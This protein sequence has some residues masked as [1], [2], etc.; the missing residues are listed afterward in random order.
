VTWTPGYDRFM[1]GHPRHAISAADLAIGIALTAFGLR[2]T[3]N[4]D[5]GGGGVWVDS[6]VIAAVTLPV[7]WRWRVPLASAAALAGGTVV[8]AIPTFDQVR[9]GAAIPAA[10]LVL[11]AVAIRS[12]KRQAI[13]GLGLLLAGM[14]FLCFTDP[15]LSWAA[16]P[17][18]VYPL[19]PLCI[20]VWAAGRVVRSRN[21]LAAELAERSRALARQRERTTQLAVEVERTWLAAQ[22]DAATRRRVREMID[23]TERGER[24]LAQDPER[25]RQV[26]AG[27]ESAGRESLNEMRGLL[28]VLRSEG[29]PGRFPQ[30]TLAQLGSLLD[31][32]RSVG[33]HV[34]FHVDGERQSLPASIEL[35]AYRM[36]EHALAAIGDAVTV[37]LRYLPDT[38][39]LE[40]S[41]TVSA[42]E[43][44]DAA[45]AAAREQV[46]THGGNFT[47]LTRRSGL[48]VLRA[49]LPVSVAHV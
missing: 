20:G 48:T 2:I 22:L 21:R 30:P 12:E 47:A 13:G 9:C 40:V 31:D 36:A 33:R 24:T 26:F 23:L 32:A 18:F 38:L 25:A 8:S 27:I 7:I 19:A 45:L 44:A 34:D 17:L 49:R 42:T 46:S 39:E 10:L 6:L 43:G 15:N 11:Y 3:L 4:P 37:R 35:A 14:L 29:E 1:T 28:G 5:N 16:V 41:G